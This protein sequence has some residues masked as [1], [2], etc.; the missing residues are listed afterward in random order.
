MAKADKTVFFCKEC[1]Y[2]SAKW[3]GRVRDVKRWGLLWKSLKVL[4][5]K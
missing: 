5:I 2:E 3:L 1:G 4:K